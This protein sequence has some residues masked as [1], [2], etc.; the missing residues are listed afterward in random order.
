MTH[1][2]TNSD[3]Y[4][5]EPAGFASGR[6][7]CGLEETAAGANAKASIILIASESIHACWHEETPMLAAAK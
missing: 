2:I 1:A 7:V 6:V 3:R 4:Q 5:E